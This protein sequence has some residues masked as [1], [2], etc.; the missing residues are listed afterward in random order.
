MR[1]VWAKVASAGLVIGSTSAI[2]CSA[3]DRPIAA[4][5]ERFVGASVPAAVDS[6]QIR[7]AVSLIDELPLAFT[8]LC[9]HGSTQREFHARGR[10]YHVKLTSDTAFVALQ[11][12]RLHAKREVGGFELIRIRFVG[13]NPAGLAEGRQP[14]PGR[15]NLFRT[16]LPDC[17]DIGNFGRVHFHDAYPDIDL[18]WYGNGHELEFDVVVGPGGDPDRIRLAIDGA[19]SLSV[20]PGGN[21]DIAVGDATLTLRKPFAYQDRLS[22]RDIVDTKFVLGTDGHVA[23]QVSA[24]DR[25]YALT[26][27]PVLSYATYLGGTR[28]DYGTAV[29]VDANGNVYVAGHTTSADFPA[30]NAYDKTLGAGDVDAFVTKLNAAGKSLVYSTLVGGAGIDRATGIAIDSAGNAY[31]TGTT[32]GSF[33]TTTGAYQPAAASTSS[34][35][36]KLGPAGN[37]LVYSTYIHGVEARG[38]AVDTSGS[39]HIAGR[40]VT[41]F[42]TTPGAYQQAPAGG[43]ALKLNA[44]GTAA[45]YATY[46]GGGGTEAANAIALDPSGNAYIGGSTTATHF[47]TTAAYQPIAGGGSDGFLVKLD[48][49]GS[50]ALYSTYLGGALDDSIN[51]VA[52]DANGNAYVAGETYSADFPAHNGFIAQKPGALLANSASGSAFVAKVGAAG[53]RLLYASFLGGEIC[54]VPCT[55]PTATPQTPG[56]AAYGIAIDNLGHAHVSGLARSYTFPLVNSLKPAKTMAAQD[57]AF[58]AKIGRTGGTLLYSTLTRTGTA[59][60]PNDFT[61]F[62]PGAATGIAVDS[63]GAVYATG[64]ADSASNFTASTGSFQTSN[65][66][67]QGAVVIKLAGTV[68]TLA[69]TASTAFVSGPAPV[70]LTAKV[71]GVTLSGSVAFRSGNITVGTAPWNGSTATLV[72]SLPVGIHALTAVHSVA[73]KEM[74]S[75]VVAVVVDSGAACD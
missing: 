45:A 18:V 27:D 13:A 4:Q 36:A 3:F 33:P 69:L 44:T 50:R 53:D 20:D 70:T 74:D 10:G 75:N 14:L 48:P 68:G 72:T 54:T 41:S 51:A 32:T 31:L 21:L 73:G 42:A 16:G 71:A 35:V 63:A 65:G 67:G 56:D 43:F 11:R 22:R 66:G 40:V 28:N 49:A 46:L 15:N 9:S 47:P 25:A 64:D 58:I 6:A 39:A 26:I 7:S 60:P 29:A 57:S 2:S 5:H 62:P 55:A 8:A 52:V 30:L 12:S 24:Y 19:D 38:I 17:T 23:L 34:F 61:R 59:S 37:A 1:G